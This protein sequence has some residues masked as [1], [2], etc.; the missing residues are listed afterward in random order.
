MKLR[1]IMKAGEIQDRI[2]VSLSRRDKEL[3]KRVSV[4]KGINL[5]EMICLAMKDIIAR[6][7]ESIGA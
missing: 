3:F 2:S 6:Q 5:S 4:R 1:K 7:E